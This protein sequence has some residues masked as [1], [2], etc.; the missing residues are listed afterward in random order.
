MFRNHPNAF[1]DIFRA[2]R[3]MAGGEAILSMGFLLIFL[4]A[5]LTYGPNIKKGFSVFPDP[6]SEARKKAKWWDL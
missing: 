5:L 4:G 6:K 2:E 3:G 1:L